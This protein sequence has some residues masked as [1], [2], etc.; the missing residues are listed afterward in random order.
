MALQLAELAAERQRSD[1]G[2]SRDSNSS[3]QLV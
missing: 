3:I 2:S 1:D